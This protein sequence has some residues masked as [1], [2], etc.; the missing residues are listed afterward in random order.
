M[1][2]MILKI[3]KSNYLL[4][5]L[6]IPLV[7]LVL[8]LPI[9]FTPLHPIN[10][11]YKWETILFNKLQLISWLNFILTFIFLNV[12]ALLLNRFFNKSH[13]F[14]KTTY[15]PAVIYLILISFSHT[16][17]FAPYIFEHF[18]LILLMTELLNL[19]QNES[20]I[21]TS[22]KMGLIIGGLYC[23]APYYL[24]LFPFTWLAL[25]ISKAF[26]V[27]E[28]LVYLIGLCVPLIWFYA[29]QFIFDSSFEF[30]NFIG[31]YSLTSQLQIIDYIQFFGFG[32]IGLINLLPLIP[33]YNHNKVVIKKQLLLISVLQFFT[34]LILIIAY[35]FFGTLDYSILLPL[36]ILISI[37][38]NNMKSDTFIS[39]L[40][41]IMLIINIVNLF[42]S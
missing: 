29:L 6:L 7:A 37:N 33:Y 36:S 23:L 5:L 2:I 35:N 12:N 1:A 22:F 10:Y 9:F 13:F 8:C 42:W 19:N 26:K 11:T 15:V 27:K 31:K 41:T 40:L 21:D 32:L 17:Y 3:Y 30:S 24:I 28:W 14:S 20:A 4:G 34:I 39:F 16:L 25:L 38:A 18:L